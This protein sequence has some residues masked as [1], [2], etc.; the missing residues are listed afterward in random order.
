MSV[1]L[2]EDSVE[3]IMI[4][5]VSSKNYYNSSL[6]APNWP[7]GNSGVTIGIGYDLAHVTEY[8]F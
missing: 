4:F 5:E 2:E 1:E 8:Q 3:M 6:K 7:G